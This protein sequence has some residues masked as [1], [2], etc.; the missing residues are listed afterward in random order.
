MQV[1]FY[2]YAILISEEKVNFRHSKDKMAETIVQDMM[3]ESDQFLVNIRR[4]SKYV[5]K[6]KSS[7]VSGLKID[8]Q[9]KSG[10]ESKSIRKF[11]VSNLDFDQNIKTDD[12]NL[13]IDL[14]V[15]DKPSHLE[16][17][18]KGR[19]KPKRTINTTN[20]K[21]IVA[22]ETDFSEFK[23]EKIEEKNDSLVLNTTHDTKKS[24]VRNS[25]NQPKIE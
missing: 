12:I 6:M 22:T 24:I 4:L 2:L 5:S 20:R 1:Y 16:H 10:D 7:A 14:E 13:D 17:L 19:P 23:N 8:N 18:N 15:S 9:E 11:I 21:K 3:Q 25:V